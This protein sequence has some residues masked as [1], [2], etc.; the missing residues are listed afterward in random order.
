MKLLLL[1]VNNLEFPKP[2]AF[3]SKEWILSPNPYNDKDEDWER[4]ILKHNIK[5]ERLRLYLKVYSL[6]QLKCLIIIFQY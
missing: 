2:T 5:P 6:L 4:I 3:A 1:H